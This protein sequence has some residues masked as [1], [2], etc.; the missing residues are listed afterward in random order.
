M[1]SLIL[2][3]V[4]RGLLPVATLFA[5]YLLWRGHNL[6]GGGFIAGLVTAGA[7]M[8]QALAFGVRATRSHVWRALRVAPWL[9]IAIAMASGLSA[10][11]FGDAML[12]QYHTYVSI[13]GT[14]LHLSTALTFDVGVYM[15]V[16]GVA[17]MAAN[18]FAE[19]IT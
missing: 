2:E 1:R 6:P 15:T 8:L 3:R 16:V 10:L 11:L 18:L 13:A 17:A 9:G 12:T 5:L 14:E 7:L 4:A 19:G